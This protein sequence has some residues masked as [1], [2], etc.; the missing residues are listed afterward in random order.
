MGFLSPVIIKFKMLF[1]ALYEEKQDWDQLLT[2]DLLQRWKTL[3]SELQS[4]PAMSMPRCFLDGVA[5]KAKSFSLHGFCDASKHAYATVIYLVIE[6]P[7][8]RF[9]KFVV[10]KTRVA[11]LKS[12]TIPRLELLSALLLARLM[13]S[14]TEC[15]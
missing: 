10:S 4:S 7:N 15:L 12:Q 11:P 13:H 9:T 1:Q 14:V 2:G 8:G 3:V 5:G 6:T